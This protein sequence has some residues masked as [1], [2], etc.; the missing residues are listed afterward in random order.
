MGFTFNC[1]HYR[2][3]NYQNIV[4]YPIFGFVLTTLD[5]AVPAPYILPVPKRNALKHPF[6]AIRFGKDLC[7]VQC[8][9]LGYKTVQ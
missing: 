6:I 1:G 2:I 7:V 4:Y 5:N 8:G 3:R 9:R